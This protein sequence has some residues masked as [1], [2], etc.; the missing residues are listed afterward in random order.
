M[1]NDQRRCWAPQAKKR[2][3]GASNKVTCAYVVFS[4][5]LKCLIPFLTTDHLSAQPEWAFSMLGHFKDTLG[6]GGEGEAVVH[7]SVGFF[8][9]TQVYGWICLM[10]QFPSLHF[11]TST[12]YLHPY[13][14]Q[15]PHFSTTDATSHNKYSPRWPLPTLP[16]PLFSGQWQGAI[17][18]PALSSKHKWKLNLNTLIFYKHFFLQSFHSNFLKFFFSHF[19]PI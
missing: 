15:Q 2:G 17:D 12:T 10:M 16:Q 13:P 5:F 3:G 11:F 7:K 8:N 18:S 6:I 1:V 4:L 19:E 9:P 14:Y